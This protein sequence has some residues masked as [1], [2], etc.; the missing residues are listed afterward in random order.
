MN[1][2]YE[3][4][5]TMI[6]AVNLAN[7]YNSYLAG[8]LDINEYLESSGIDYGIVDAYCNFLYDLLIELTDRDYDL[9][10][11]NS[12]EDGHIIP[13][14]KFDTV[15]TL[16]MMSTLEDYDISG[17]EPSQI[18]YTMYQLSVNAV[19]FQVKYALNSLE[20]MRSDED[21]WGEY[22]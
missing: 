12:I 8:A 3:Y 9:Q 5:G 22:L 14:Q 18:Q 13:G 21:L 7:M 19:K 2:L 10:Y 17:V 15:V 16:D 20:Y 1:N 11:N 6:G 4:D